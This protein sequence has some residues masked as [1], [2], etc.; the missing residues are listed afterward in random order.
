[1]TIFPSR[2]M[3]GFQRT[4][5]LSAF[6]MINYDVTKRPS[7]L[8]GMISVD[9]IGRLTFPYDYAGGE[10]SVYRHKA[11]RTAAYLPLFSIPHDPAAEYFSSKCYIHTYLGQHAYTSCT[12]LLCTRHGHVLTKP[13]LAHP[14]GRPYSH[15]T[16]E[17]QTSLL[18]LLACLGSALADMQTYITSRRSGA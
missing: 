7:T 10:V 14:N 15:Q 12:L 11:L 6:N 13:N 1:M 8:G 2:R 17:L 4:I 5:W 9:L 18:A 16:F 3:E